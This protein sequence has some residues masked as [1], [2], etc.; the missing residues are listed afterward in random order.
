MRGISVDGRI[1]CIEDKEQGAPASQADHRRDP[2][3]PF[4]QATNHEKA[5][6]AGQGGRRTGLT[7]APKP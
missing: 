2:D 7:P 5:P 3:R 6:A 4:Q 1:V